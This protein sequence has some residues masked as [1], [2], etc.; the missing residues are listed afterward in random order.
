M[1]AFRS[2]AVTRSRCLWSECKHTP[3]S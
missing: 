3:A 1:V 2:L